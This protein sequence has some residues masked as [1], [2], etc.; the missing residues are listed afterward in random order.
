MA[1]PELG[2]QLSLSVESESTLELRLVATE[3]GVPGWVA[4]EMQL[5]AP[6]LAA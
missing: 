4:P 3:L 1:A 6:V 5:V 2:V